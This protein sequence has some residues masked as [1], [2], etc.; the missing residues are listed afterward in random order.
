M[1]SHGMDGT[2]RKPGAGSS[3][4]RNERRRACTRFSCAL[5]LVPKLSLGTHLH[6]K[7]CFKLKIMKSLIKNVKNAAQRRPTRNRK[8]RSIRQAP[9]QC[10]HFAAYG[11]AGYPAYPGST[12]RSTRFLQ[13]KEG[14]IPKMEHRFSRQIKH[15]CAKSS[16]IGQ[17]RAFLCQLNK[18]LIKKRSPSINLNQFF[19][20]NKTLR[21]SGVPVVA[22]S[23]L[24]RGFLTTPRAS[25][26][27]QFV[28]WV[29]RSE[30]HQHDLRTGAS[31]VHW[32]AGAHCRL[33]H[34]T[35]TN[36]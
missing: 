8:Q 33:V 25:R 2:G 16:K 18:A 4:P 7:L 17:N 12:N 13:E 15:F 11:D 27:Q 36:S 32:C 24:W 3:E 20:V 21:R 9:H 10:A 29:Q 22:W 26:Y 6:L 34:R 35:I 23:L 31:Q 14:Q 28:G 19:C 1:T 30:T 5:P